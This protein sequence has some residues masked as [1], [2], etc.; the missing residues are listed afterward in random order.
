MGWCLFI[1]KFAWDSMG[2]C[3]FIR[4][5][6]S[7]VGAQ[8][9]FHE[10]SNRIFEISYNH[11]FQLMKKKQILLKEYFMM[12]FNRILW[13]GPYLYVNLVGIVWV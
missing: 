10:I 1:H 3:L 4:F 12:D 6:A 5:S 11:Q 13:L 9:D 8:E 2:L 7:S